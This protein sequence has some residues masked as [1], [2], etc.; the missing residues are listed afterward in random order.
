[1]RGWGWGYEG[2]MRVHGAIL[3]SLGTRQVQQT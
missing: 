1:M 3:Y 2:G